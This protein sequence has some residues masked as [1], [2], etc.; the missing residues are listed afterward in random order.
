M[1]EGRDDDKPR[2]WR[3]LAERYEC[4]SVRIFCSNHRTFRYLITSVGLAVA[5]ATL[6]FSCVEFREGREVREA[7]LFA[8]ATERLEAARA[9]DAGYDLDSMSA[10]LAKSGYLNEWSALEL[11]SEASTQV[12][13]TL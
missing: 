11:A 13:S 2:W 1:M 9:E 3:K 8:L 7:T 4:T 6:M 12:V 10:R 5:A